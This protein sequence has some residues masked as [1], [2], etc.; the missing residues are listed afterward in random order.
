[1]RGRAARATAAAAGAVLLASLVAGTAVG[2]DESVTLNIWSPENRP[3]DAAAHAWLIERFE[4][5]NPD[6]Q[7]EVTTTSWDDHFAKVDAASAAGNLPD[8]VYSW[9]PNTAALMDKGELA[10]I[11]DVWATIGVENLPAGEREVL[12]EG[13]AI[14]AIP[15]IG[16]PH[17]L[18]YR[19]D[20]FEEA[21]LEPPQT[22]DDIIEAARALTNDDRSGICLFGKG[23]DAYYVTDLMLAAG[24]QA[25]DEEGNIT[26]DSPETV[27][28]L[29]FIKTI[30]DEGLT[31]EGWTAMNM[32]DAKL[33]FIAGKCAMKIDSASFLGT[34][35]LDNPEL[36]A[37]VGVV[38]I[39]LNGGQFAGWAG[40][41]AYGVTAASSHQEE[42]KRFLEFMFQ[43]ESYA[44]FIGRQVLG[45]QPLLKA[46]AEGTELYE[47][48]RIA[49]VADIY[50]G[51]AAAAAGGYPG[52]TYSA[53]G[54]STEN[55]LIYNQQVYAD[56]AARIE[57][58]ESPE[59]VAAWA[60]D[61][62]AELV[63]TG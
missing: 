50:R 23:L 3:D 59:D 53:P 28:V 54:T 24:A 34:L 62:I 32:D 38:P 30:N 16:Y 43:P 18:W 12:S 33:P 8:L 15:F 57:Q 4:A 63:Q 7:V 14:Y 49:P 37:N 19:A 6:I 31:P 29:E 26:I 39:P 47:Q 40:A 25:F 21:G 13:D 20:W 10:D 1:M 61:R 48:E 56:M 52:A 51:A 9:Q 60:A 11:S 36:L 5:A 44:G 35:D 55:A 2:Q 22:W 46:V 42:A 27:Q 45:F 41:S 58:G 17:A